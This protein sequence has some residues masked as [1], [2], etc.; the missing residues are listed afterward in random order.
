MKLGVLFPVQECLKIS[1]IKDGGNYDFKLRKTTYLMG[2]KECIS[3]V[4]WEMP[5][6]EKEKKIRDPGQAPY[7]P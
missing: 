2:F 1:P 4:M 7:L 3:L 5:G 6:C